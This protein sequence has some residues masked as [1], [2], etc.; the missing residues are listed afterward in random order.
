M[1]SPPAAS[2]SPQHRILLW[3]L[4]FPRGGP[5]EVIVFHH[6]GLFYW[7]PVWLTGFIMAGITYFGD[8]H[9]AIVPAGTEAVPHIRVET[10]AGDLEERDALVLPPGKKLLTHKDPEGKDVLD[11]PTIFVAHAKSVGTLFMIILLIV[12]VLT[13]ITM[14]GLWSVFVIVVL[15]MGSII[16]AA[17]G[18]WDVI[19][20]RFRLLS[21]HINLGA[22]LFLSLIL[23]GLWLLNFFYFDRQI[24]MVFTAGQVRMRLEIGGGETVFDTVG[25]VLHKKRSDLFRHW[26]LGFGS[27][28][29]VIRPTGQNFPIELTNVLSVLKRIK[30]IE[31]LVKEKV[32]VS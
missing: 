5:G 8:K 1:A 13:N 15:I 17:A 29:L 23:F 19:F 28:D 20:N 3:R 26:I 24:Y 14:P 25:M 32:I 31:V 18:W 4:L 27:G 30:E 12:I 11:Q 9:M 16:F 22:Y 21:I 2:P 10:R 6:S 7:W